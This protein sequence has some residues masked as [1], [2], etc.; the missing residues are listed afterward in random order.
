[1]ASKSRESRSSLGDRIGR[2]DSGLARQKGSKGL[3]TFLSVL[4]AP[5]TAVR[6]ARNRSTKLLAVYR[7]YSDV[8]QEKR[9]VEW[10]ESL[11]RGKHSN[12]STHKDDPW[13]TAV[14]R[15]SPVRL[16]PLVGA[17]RNSRTVER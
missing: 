13:P 5:V 3:V 8:E 12:L 17:V 14:R 1:M 11:L 9:T 16:E 10:S 7:T 2:R 6:I 4:A 15:N